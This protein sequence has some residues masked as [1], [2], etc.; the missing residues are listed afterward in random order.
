MS[1]SFFLM[2]SGKDEVEL[3]PTDPMIPFPQG[4]IFLSP[5]LGLARAS[6]GAASSLRLLEAAGAQEQKV[7]EKTEN[8]AIRLDTGYS[9]SKA[10]PTSALVPRYS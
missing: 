10:I 5:G 6:A 1:T 7:Q 9:P 8:A 4:G 2:I 3:F